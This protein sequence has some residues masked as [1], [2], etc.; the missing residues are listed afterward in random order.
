M[1]LETTELDF[2]D[3][4]ANGWPNLL[5]TWSS[6]P[7]GSLE[8]PLPQMAH[9]GQNGGGGNNSLPYPTLQIIGQIAINISTW[10]S[11]LESQRTQLL[12]SCW[13]SGTRPLVGSTILW[14]LFICCRMA[15]QLS[16]QELNTTVSSKSPV[17][18]RVNQQGIRI[19]VSPKQR[20]L[21]FLG[22]FLA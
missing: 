2:R 4:K 22:P 8:V 19:R 16:R 5:R 12:P 17:L 14:E 11:F 13:Q 10:C 20:G 9:K 3:P 1:L 6:V 18:G 7:W 15:I 21:V